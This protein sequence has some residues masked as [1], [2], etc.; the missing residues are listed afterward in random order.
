[1]GVSGVGSGGSYSNFEQLAQLLEQSPEVLFDKSTGMYSVAGTEVSEE[2]V[3][4]ALPHLTVSQGDLYDKEGRPL[5]T[6]YGSAAATQFGEGRPVPLPDV[7]GSPAAPGEVSGK[8]EGI[9]EIPLASLMF[10]A[11][12]E[13][14][15]V[16]SREQA[17]ATKFRHA[18]QEQ[19]DKAK[20]AALEATDKQIEA[21]RAAAEEQFI[22]MAC[23]AIVVAV[24]Q[25]LANLV[26]AGVLGAGAGS[27]LATAANVV[28]AVA[29][30]VGQ[31]VTT[32]VDIASKTD[33]HQK[34]ANEKEIETKEQELAEAEFDAALDSAKSTAESAKE[35]FKMALNIILET[36]ERQS[37]VVQKLTA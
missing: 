36:L 16:S 1:M 23:V 22:T 7:P 2:A 21:D 31:M 8:L 4:S 15:R 27:G 12:Y 20:D 17:D 11:L 19:K 35:Q 5:S 29:Q 6:T 33:G 10:M 9:Q 3:Q 25:I 13:M 32:G 26:G 14:A 18:M 24:V 34:R 37:Q 28:A 30:P